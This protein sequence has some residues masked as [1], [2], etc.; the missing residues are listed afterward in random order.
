MIQSH[1][2]SKSWKFQLQSSLLNLSVYESETAKQT[3]DYIEE[4][5]NSINDFDIRDI[6]KSILGNVIDECQSQSPCENEGGHHKEKSNPNISADATS[7][8]DQV[9]SNYQ[10]GE[11]GKVFSTEASTLDHVSKNHVPIEQTSDELTHV[12][13]NCAKTFLTEGEKE[14]HMQEKHRISEC[15]KCSGLEKANDMLKLR[16]MKLAFNESLRERTE[17]NRE[18]SAQRDSLAEEL[19]ENTVLNE[20]VRVKENIIKIMKEATKE[21]NGSKDNVDSNESG[22][23][24]AIKNKLQLMLKKK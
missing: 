15:D 8:E 1:W 20:E 2:R 11:C 7:S 4:K 6:V 5:D 3:N 12:C 18:L 19:K 23:G 22:Q 13:G 17:L 10:C 9:D 16:R 21:Q 14:S 24:T